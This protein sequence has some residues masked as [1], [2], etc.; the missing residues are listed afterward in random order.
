MGGINIKESEALDILSMN[1]QCDIRWNWHTFQWISFLRRRKKY[2][3]S[4]DLLTI[5]SIY[6]R[7]RMEYKSHV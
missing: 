5:Y 3:T 1:I 6:I 4:A 2:F 7:K